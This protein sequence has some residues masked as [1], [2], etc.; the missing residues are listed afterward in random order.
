MAPSDE[1]NN[2]YD[3][4]S[5]SITMA[6]HQPL[7]SSDDKAQI[8]IPI[9]KE[10]FKNTAYGIN[11]ELP[12]VDQFLA[13]HHDSRRRR[14]S[15]TVETPTRST[16]SQNLLDKNAIDV[17]CPVAT[18]PSTNRIRHGDSNLEYGTV[19]GNGISLSV[20]HTKEESHAFD[21]SMMERRSSPIQQNDSSSQ[22]TPCSKAA[23]LTT[24]TT[25]DS[26]NTTQQQSQS[27]MIKNELFN[28]TSQQQQQPIRRIS[29]REK[30]KRDIPLSRVRVKYDMQSVPF[31]RRNPSFLKHFTPPWWQCNENTCILNHQRIEVG[32]KASQ[33]PQKRRSS[34][35]VT[36]T[37]STIDNESSTKVGG[38]TQHNDQNTCRCT[39]TQSQQLSPFIVDDEVG[40]SVVWIPNKRSEW[41]D[42]I[43]EMTAVYTSASYRRHNIDILKKRQKEVY[44]KDNKTT[45]DTAASQ[46]FKPPL[47]SDYIRD[48]IDIDDPLYGYQIRHQFHGWMQ[49]F[50]LYTTFTTWNYGF[51]WDS[52]HPLCGISQPSEINPENQFVDYDNSLAS[53][54]ET[55]SRSGDPKVGGI[56]FPEI[57][58]IAVLG[59]LGCG[60]YLLRMVLDDLYRNK[61]QY[62]YVVLHAADQARSFYERFGFIRVGAS[63]QYNNS[64][65]TITKKRKQDHLENEQLVTGHPTVSIEQPHEGQKLI[66]N[67]VVTTQ[68]MGYRHWTHT[69][70]TEYSIETLHGAPS[71][72]M[73]LKLPDRNTTIFGTNNLEACC[74]ECGGIGQRPKPGEFLEQLLK[75]QVQAKPRIEPLY[76]STTPGPK[77]SARRSNS[78]PL[79]LASP[80]YDSQSSYPST[81]IQW[82]NHLSVGKKGNVRNGTSSKLTRRK[83]MA[84]SPVSETEVPSSNAA[85]HSMR[86]MK[87]LV[88][89]CINIMPP[90]RVKRVIEPTVSSEA[91]MSPSNEPRSKRMKVEQKKG[92]T[93]SV[94]K[95]SN[96]AEK[97]YN[98]IWL[99]VPP[100]LHGDI[101]SRRHRPPPKPRNG[102]DMSICRK[103]R[104]KLSSLADE[105]TS[106]LK[107]MLLTTNIP[108][109]DV[110]TRTIKQE[111]LSL[112]VIEELHERN[113]DKK[114]KQAAEI[115]DLKRN[116][117][118]GTKRQ[119][120]IG[121]MVSD[122]Y[123][124]HY[125]PPES[126]DA[127]R[128]NRLQ[129]SIRT[130]KQR[131]PTESPTT[132]VDMKPSI[133]VHATNVTVDMKSSQPR[134]SLFDIIPSG[135]LLLLDIKT[136]RKQKVLSYPRNRIHYYN[137]IVKQNIILLE[138]SDTSLSESDKSY[139]FVLEYNE[140]TGLICIVPMTV[141]GTLL[142]KRIGRPRYQCLLPSENDDNNFIIVDAK[143]Y[144]VVPSA[145]IMKTPIIAQEAWDISTENDIDFLTR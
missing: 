145:M 64:T 57:A 67:P 80:S 131:T 73:C 59:A 39:M 128:S 130:I 144:Q 143:Q 118:R 54:L 137:R 37:G 83:S 33:E 69:N 48:R 89:S 79:L 6:D 106:S 4:A 141:R 42:T 115:N 49:G 136:L 124:E 53:E 114:V 117:K 99:A 31:V 18:I 30:P 133:D 28:N 134:L 13:V 94:Q 17:V 77:Y 105:S 116:K 23:I 29:T 36:T 72:M 110:N 50:I 10:V 97:Q 120:G 126:T 58:E 135:G 60:E 11:Y 139:Y 101:S 46:Q 2:Q 61:P 40:G 78:M 27:D 92:T 102:I 85:H 19:T 22:L 122:E 41:E 45:T 55:L 3:S 15:H 111:Q 98:S 63:C 38:T 21:S 7:S 35:L 107:D 81:A 138:D 70:E 104:K 125:A 95:R 119:P 62:K 84:P 52:S 12:M 87:P 100:N 113:S 26:D 44:Q 56:V 47:S 16:Q 127:D 8:P 1:N 34:R 43:A 24:E 103:S 68:V 132:T 112:P 129:K 90:K 25:T 75:F 5:I 51:Q 76:T 32:V 66:T 86:I 121:E 96:F 109:H 91:S 71:Y 88:S 140:E 82:M 123:T 9:P 108:K 14:M 74:V 142:G 93:S 20:I 65:P